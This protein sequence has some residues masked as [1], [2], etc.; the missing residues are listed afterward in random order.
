MDGG[1]GAM[2]PELHLHGRTA[3]D[4]ERVLERVRLEL[5]ERVE[6]LLLRG[7]APHPLDGE[8]PDLRV[9][10]H[11]GDEV[12]PALRVHQPVRVDDVLLLAPALLRVVAHGDDAACHARFEQLRRRLVGLRVLALRLRRLRRDDARQPVEELL[13]RRRER[14]LELV[15]RALQIVEHRRAGEALEQRAAEIER[16]QLGERQPASGQRAD[17][18]GVHAPEL[19]A[20]DRL[21]EDGEAGRLQRGQ[22]AADR[23]RRDVQVLGQLRNRVRPRC[24]PAAEGASTGGSA[25][26]CVP[27]RPS[28]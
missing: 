19:R 18:L 21:V 5:G 7:D 17:G 20:V 10:R 25:R 23:A 6:R 28:R 16:A 11:E 12:E 9:R 3:V 22:V 15:E 24:R 2:K 4:A 27:S 8:R 26:C 13:H 1:D 14:G